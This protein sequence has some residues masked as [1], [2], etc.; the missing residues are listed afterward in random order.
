MPK[1]EVEISA[2]RIFSVLKDLLPKEWEET[3]TF[4]NNKKSGMFHIKLRVFSQLLKR[5]IAQV[6][7]L[8]TIVRIEILDNR[9][10][11]QLTD[12]AT[13]FEKENIRNV[14]LKSWTP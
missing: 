1:I 9:Y 3:D 7:I 12:L 14:T 8:S 2:Q 11:Q 13:A 4:F 6:Y 10:K 5:P